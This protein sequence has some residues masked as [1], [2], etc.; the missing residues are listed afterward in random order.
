[1]RRMRYVKAVTVVLACLGWLWPV[2]P[3]S[4]VPPA[5]EATASPAA[6]Q[7]VR[8]GDGGTLAGQL[9]D[10]HGQPVAQQSVALLQGTKALVETRTDAAGRFAFRQVRSGVV[11]LTEG[12]V[13][14]ACRVWTKAAAPPAA[15]G[16][17]LLVAEADVVR[18]QQ[19]LSALFTNPL[20]IGLIIAAAIAIPLAIAHQEKSSGS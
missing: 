7:D 15:Q 19:P 11:Q 18:G 3:V 16:Q 14:V 17:A 8:L 12:T 20:V 6:F 4:A 5:A 9:L 13:C 10:A 1:M 2:P